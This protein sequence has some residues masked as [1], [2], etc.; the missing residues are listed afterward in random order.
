MSSLL[1]DTSAYSAFKRGHTQC[2]ETISAA[3][4]IGIT[5]IVIGELLAGFDRGRYRQENRRELK[6]FLAHPT[7]ALFPVTEQTA[8]R[9]SFIYQHLRTAGT[10]IPTNDVWIAAS[11][12]ENGSILLT[13]DR[14]FLQVPQIQTIMLQTNG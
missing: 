13:A 4:Q 11:T 7:V 12:M 3:D 10:P 5:P 9:Y 6:A 2:L 1:L 8:E 14:H